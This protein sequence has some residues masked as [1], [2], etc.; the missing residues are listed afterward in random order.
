MVRNLHRSCRIDSIRTTGNTDKVDTGI[1]CAGGTC[2]WD[3]DCL[4]VRREISMRFLLS[5]TLAC[6]AVACCG[7]AVAQDKLVFPYE[8]PQKVTATKKKRIPRIQP[9][10]GLAPETVARLIHERAMMQ[11]RSR[12]ARIQARKWAGISLLRPTVSPVRPFPSDDW[13]APT[14]SPWWWNSS[15]SRLRIRW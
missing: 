5:S 4:T 6:V 1:L 10:I 9:R 14:G 7:N 2:N 15:R 13:R 8:K 3:N 12:R 11:A